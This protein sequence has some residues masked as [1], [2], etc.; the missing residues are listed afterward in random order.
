R[1]VC[2]A[3]RASARSENSRRSPDPWIQSG[4]GAWARRS[5][6]LPYWGAARETSGNS[7]K[8]PAHLDGLGDVEVVGRGRHHDLVDLLILLGGAVAHEMD[9][10]VDPPATGR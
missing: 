6:G 10:V 4:S 3:A 9:D 8:T 1:V 2:E 5:R 7:G